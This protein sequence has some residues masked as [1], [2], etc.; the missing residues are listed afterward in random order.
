MHQH[1]F[2]Q[3]EHTHVITIQIKNW[4]IADIQ[5]PLLSLAFPGHSHLLPKINTILNPKITHAFCL[6]LALYKWNC[7][8]CFILCLVSLSPHYV[9]EIHPCVVGS[10]I[11]LFSLLCY[12]YI[13]R[14]YHNSCIHSTVEHV[15]CFQF[16]GY[17]RFL[18]MSFD[19]Y[20]CAFL[21]SI[22]LGVVLLCPTIRIHSTLAENVNQCVTTRL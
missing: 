3:S 7:T 5:T 2:S 9:G 15:E 14:T 17:Y 11:S 13:V 1:E 22:N 6:F 12:I 8:I 10:S 16:W 21:M 4:N 19:T 18:C 20:M